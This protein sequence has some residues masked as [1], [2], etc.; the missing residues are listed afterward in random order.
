MLRLIEI[1]VFSMPSKTEQNIDNSECFG[2]KF[3]CQKYWEMSKK[4]LYNQPKQHFF[5]KYCEVISG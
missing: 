3:I 2:V 1:D 5:K 4:S